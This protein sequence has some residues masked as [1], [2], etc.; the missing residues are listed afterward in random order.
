MSAGEASAFPRIDPEHPLAQA[1]R[2]VNERATLYGLEATL[3]WLGIGTAG[4]LAYLAEQRAL[5]AIAANMGIVMGDDAQLDER[6]ARTIVETPLWQDMRTLLV[7]CYLDAFAIAWKGRELAEANGT[8][9]HFDDR[10]TVNVEVALE[11]A[12][13]AYRVLHGALDI[14]GGGDARDDFEAMSRALD[15]VAVV[16]QGLGSNGATAL[17]GRD[18]A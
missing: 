11:R 10:E 18:D 16:L 9:D 4:E 7:G 3:E 15:C 8:P 12:Q 13:A 1:A 5:R 17:A 6:I 2:E 14:G